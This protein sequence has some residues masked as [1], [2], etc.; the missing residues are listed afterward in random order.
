MGLKKK[1]EK[2][3][4]LTCTHER[5]N[6]EHHTPNLLEKEETFLNNIYLISFSLVSVY[7]GGRQIEGENDRAKERDG[8]G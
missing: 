6:R 2:N 4:F 1:E 7:G 3:I 5:T 8:A